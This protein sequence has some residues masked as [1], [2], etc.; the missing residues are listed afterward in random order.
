MLEIW[1]ATAICRM[2]LMFGD[3]GPASKSFIQPMI[4]NLKAGRSVNLF[5]DE[6]RTMASASTASRGILL[7][8]EKGVSGPLHLGGRDRVSR[9]DFGR[10]LARLLDADQALI[11]P[12]RQRD[13]VSEA[14]RPPDVSLDS[15]LAFSFGYD[16]KPL[17]EEL[18]EVLGEIGK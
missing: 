8:L 2:P 3:G 9:H 7:A 11:V 13:V 16:P 18:R 17:E 12:M 5:V 6:F 15:S 10:L 1:P 4:E 14:P